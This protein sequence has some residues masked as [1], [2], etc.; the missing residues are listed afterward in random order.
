MPVTSCSPCRSNLGGTAPRYFV[1]DAID[2]F[3]DASCSL[4]K[5]GAVQECVSE[6][7]KA[8][9]AAEGAPCVTQRDGYFVV[10]S[11]LLVLGVAIIY[12]FIAPTA[13]RLQRAI[14]VGGDHV[15]DAHL[16]AGVPPAA[17]RIT[18]GKTR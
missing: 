12:G 17:W 11:A 2:R 4:A 15:R 10:S 1:L 16:R 14:A 5:S 6:A 3:T 8:I 18:S 9:C 13:H 7:G